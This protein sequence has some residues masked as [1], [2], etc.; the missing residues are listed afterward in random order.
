MAGHGCAWHGLPYSHLSPL[1]PFSAGYGMVG[2]GQA[3]Q[4]LVVAWA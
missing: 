1:P 4:Q 2:S 3:V